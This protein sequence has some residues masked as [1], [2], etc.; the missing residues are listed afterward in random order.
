MK[1]Q[2][3]T[4]SI[5]PKVASLVTI[6]MSMAAMANAAVVADIAG[7]YI[8][9]ASLPANWGYF[10]SNQ[11]SGGSEV[12]LTPDRPIGNGGNRGFGGDASFF[13]LPG[14]IGTKIVDQYEIFGD[15]DANVPVLGTDLLLHPGLDAANNTVII[16]YTISLADI[17]AFGAVAGIAG[18]FRN[19]IPNGDSVTVSIYHNATQLFTQNG[20]G[21]ILTEAN[22]TFDISGLSVSANDTISFAVN[23]NTNI[24][25][26]ETALRGTIALVPEPSACALLAG[27]LCVLL[28]GRRRNA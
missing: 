3:T 18:S 24:G 11:A 28:V 9:P 14:L 4:T 7:N 16:R 26:D 19:L 8:S 12:A 23:A 17:N 22:G 5:A 10:Y 15:G 13:Y 1:P 27:S 25:A 2:P 6:F 20:S 21:G